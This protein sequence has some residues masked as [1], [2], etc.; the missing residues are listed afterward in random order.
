MLGAMKTYVY[1]AK[2]ARPKRPDGRRLKRTADNAGQGAIHNNDRAYKNISRRR[3]SEMAA[4]LCRHTSGANVAISRVRTGISFAAR[5][6][7]K[8]RSHA[9]LDHRAAFKGYKLS[10]F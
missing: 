5:C 10:I 4:A 7:A 1:G 9:R 6:S 3:H 2:L 8:C